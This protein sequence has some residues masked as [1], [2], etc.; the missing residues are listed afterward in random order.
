MSIEAHTIQTL[1]HSLSGELVNIRRYIHQNPELSFHEFQTTEYIRQLL[2]SWGI[3]ILDYGLDNGVVGL[4]RGNQDNG[5][6]IALRADLDALPIHELTGKEYASAEQGIMHACGHDAHTTC[7]LGAAKI[8]HTLREQ[9]EGSIKLIFQPGEEKFP[10]G[11]S[12]LIEK[13]V[14]ENPSVDAAIALHVYPELEAGKVGFRSGS[15]M[16]SA[17]EIYITIHGT[18]GH[19][20][21]PHIQTDA[22]YVASQVI[23]NLQAVISRM[24]PASV[25]AVLSFGRMIADGATNVLPPKVEIAGT[26]RCMDETWRKT[27]HAQIF[28]VVQGIT[29]AY[30]A[31]HDME[32]LNGYPSLYNDPL[33]TENC[34]VAARE[35][36]GEDNVVPLDIRMTAE[37]FAWYSRKAPVCFFRLGTGG[38]GDQNRH[39]V[40]SPYFDIDENALVTGAG[41]MAWL[42]T[43]Y[44]SR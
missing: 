1:A 32:I 3:E 19:G 28:S 15:Y 9:W 41:M 42:G 18:G 5:K 25:P 6:C 33:L 23:V 37:D 17:D 39:S 20:A 43:R 13:G 21:L 14:L 22:V 16:A 30:N 31:R 40:H 36:V 8:L 29:S 35:Y 38:P 44:L 24:M 11:A 10:G 4:L 34:S 2:T 27:A 12:L 7:L 26:F